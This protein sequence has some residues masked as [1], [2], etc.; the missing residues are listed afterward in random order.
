MRRLV[1]LILIPV[2][3]L[4]LSCKGRQQAK[5]LPEAAA[6]NKILAG[7]IG[8]KITYRVKMGALRLGR[9]YFKHVEYIE[10]GAGPVSLMTF[11]TR[12]ARFNDLEKIYIDCETLL[13]LKIERGVKAWAVKEEIIEE[14]NQKEFTLTVTKRNGAKQEKIFIKKDKPIHNTVLLPFSVRDTPELNIGWVFPAN[15]PTQ[16]F[17]IRLVSLEEIRVPAGI[18]KSYHFQ[19]T[20][21]KFEIWISADSRRIPLKIKGAGALGYTLEME[22]YRL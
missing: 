19:S 15:F 1:F 11:E 13:P 3:L 2:L 20:P 4:N 16:E 7:R 8:E 6:K 10:T 18:F 5:D 12:L 22:E 21:R 17:Q 9:A 14:Y